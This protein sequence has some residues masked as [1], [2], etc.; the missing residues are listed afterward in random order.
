M[1]WVWD[2]KG[3]EKSE[4][5]SHVWGLSSQENAVPLMGRGEMGREAGAINSSP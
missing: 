1:D 3:R 5:G 4:G 2:M